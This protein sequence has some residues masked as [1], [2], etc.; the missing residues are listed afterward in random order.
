MLIINNLYAGYD[1]RN[2][3]LKGVDLDIEEGQVIAILGRNGSGKSTLAKAICGMVPHITGDIRLKETFI[4]GLPTHQITRLG[5][6]FFQQGG[7]IFPNLTVR[8][9]LAAAAI[10]LSNREIQKSND[11][12]ANCFELLKSN[13][14]NKLK[15]TYL[16][17]GEK[18]QLA[19]AMVLLQNP[20]LLILDEPSAGLSPGNQKAMYDNLTHIRNTHP[21]TM[22]I[23]EQNVELAKGFCGSDFWI[24]QE[25][26]LTQDK[27]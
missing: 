15:A 23:I 9:N 22:L 19:L 2:P 12:I 7:K 24:V 21:V 1:S 27:Y 16:S 13:D 11:L 4:S 5:I 10:G 6:G 20:K 18:H 3:I 14:R 17:G 25:G 8:E 26:K